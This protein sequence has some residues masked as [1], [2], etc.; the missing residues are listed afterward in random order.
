M[1]KNANSFKKPRTGG[2]AE[3]AAN[4]LTSIDQVEMFADGVILIRGQEL[5]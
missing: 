1:S 5:Q 3:R 4:L 2:E